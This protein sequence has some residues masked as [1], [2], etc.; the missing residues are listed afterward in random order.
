MQAIVTPAPAPR[1]APDRATDAGP[2]AAA[3]RRS[4][5]PVACALDIV[6]DRWT[7]LLI[8]DLFRGKSRFGDFLTSA[9]HI[10][11]NILTDRLRRLTG[12]GLVNPEPY[13]TR[14]TRYAYVLTPRGRELAPVVDAMAAWGLAQFPGT[15]LPPRPTP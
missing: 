8:R 7:L 3:V 1:P 15:R 9:E 6:G 10:P 4:A 13:Q 2:N 14:P 12:A 11:T 5:C